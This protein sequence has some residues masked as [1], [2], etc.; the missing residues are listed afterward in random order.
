VTFTL[1]DTE[2]N[3]CSITAQ[4]SK[5]GTSWS[6][7]TI[8]G[9]IAGVT[10]SPT[11]G[12]KSL[13]WKSYQDQQSGQGAYQ[14]RIQAYDGTAYSTWSVP[15]SVNLNN[16]PPVNNTP[17]QALNLRIR[18]INATT[19]QEPV[20]YHDPFT[21][22]KLMA[23][24]S[25]SDPD[26]D[27]ESGSELI[28][29]KN[30][31]RF[32]SVNIPPEQ[33]KILNQT[34]NRGETWYYSITPKDGKANG[35][36]RTS[37][38]VTIGNAPP[39]VG[40]LRF[41]PL[42]PTSTTGLKA[43]FQYSDP[44]ND[45][46]GTH[47]IRWYKAAPQSSQYFLQSKYNDSLTVSA[48]DVKRSEKW[49][50][51]ITPKD[52]QGGVGVL[53]ESA[54]ILIANQKPFI[55][56]VMVSGSSGDIGITFDLVD[57]DGD[58]CEIRA[59]YR[60]GAAEKRAAT[61][62]GYTQAKNV[63]TN[64]QPSNGLRITW[65]SKE[66][67]PS[68]KDDFLFGIIP[69]DGA[70]DGDEGFSQRFPLNNNNAPTASDARISPASP[71][72][73][74]D[75]FAN[76]I[77]QDP[78]NDQESGSKIR[79]YRNR[80]EQSEYRDRKDVPNSAT[81]KGD[82]WYFTVEPGDGKEF[83]PMVQSP[84]V[85]IQNSAPQVIDVKLE[86]A[87]AT[88]EDD[89]IANYVYVDADS[90]KETGTQ[91][92]WYLD[93]TLKP[94]YNDKYIIP[95]ADTLRSQTWYFTI[96]TSDGTESSS[97]VESNHVK[98]GNVAPSVINLFVP[99]DG[100][101]DV[102]VTFDLVDPNN[103][104][105]SLVI[106]YRGG[107]VSN[108]TP[109]TIIE[110]LTGLSPGHKTL[111]WQSNKDQDV[112]QATKFQL[113]IT[114]N[115]G[116]TKGIPVE[117]TFIT[118]DNNIPP[119][120]SNVK[121][122]PAN[123][124][125]SDN[126]VASY[127]F[128]D[129]D[130]GKDMGSEIRWYKNNGVITDFKGNVLSSSVT[131]KGEK[132]YFIVKPK[133]GARF[134]NPVT[135]PTVTIA[136]SPPVLKSVEILPP[137]PRSDGK[138]TA[139][140]DYRDIDEDRESGTEIEWYRNGELKVKKAITSDTDKVL[141]LA[142]AKNEKWH[143]IVKPSDGFDFGVPMTSESVVVSNSSPRVDNLSVSGNSG[144]IIISL[145]LIDLDNDRCG[146]SIEYQGGTALSNWVKATTIEAVANILPSKGLSEPGL[147]R[148]L[149]SIHL[150]WNIANN[151]STSALISFVSLLSFFTSSVIFNRS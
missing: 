21:G 70:E 65:R 145:D 19:N 134:G 24:Y 58:T 84:S 131:V 88:S 147:F 149:A 51:T 124:T 112:R 54:A 39:S 111:T 102:P 14:F 43:L 49:K 85:K 126:L 80:T 30:G 125:T 25:F 81:T 63:I 139:K 17:P 130:G 136:N 99:E 42:Q 67:E 3:P 4:Y 116:S 129:E 44:E 115:D 95:N 142:I 151:L 77:F 52:N 72:T 148:Y 66:D 68:S 82:E 108:W 29:Y 20:P 23:G 60:K 1:Q 13:A 91:I 7:A 138:L 2:N 87:N 144:N 16:T 31:V 78:N 10:P 48:S 113:R 5:D 119:V 69:N 90:D 94:E 123:P 140:Y 22:N 150:L 59:W 83:G 50:F 74:N 122:N 75:L 64:L 146:L 62:I 6:G 92:R 118:L 41:E 109:A 135:S 76:Y 32:N 127:D 35:E 15:T 47:E 93:G 86:P 101:K 53:V 34:V 57:Q 33:N 38:T 143:I 120:A 45:P 36:T 98:L 37:N 28:W 8:Y 133:D 96:K 107:L 11:P 100:F 26:G 40:N 103:D 18:A 46:Q 106:E 55:Q 89:L 132:W 56:N 79:W 97:L 137:N 71:N 128:Y 12:S 9:D 104:I 141:P 61:L 73:A 27:P 114:P 121:V 105:I 117:S 110:P